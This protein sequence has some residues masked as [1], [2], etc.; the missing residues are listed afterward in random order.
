MLKLILALAR[1]IILLALFSCL[2]KTL[3]LLL[4]T[5]LLALEGKWGLMDY[6]IAFT[7]TGVIATILLN[8]LDNVVKRKS[9]S[10]KGN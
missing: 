9:K 10:L 3:G 8:E 1:V 5:G 7:L 6:P 4:A 2:I